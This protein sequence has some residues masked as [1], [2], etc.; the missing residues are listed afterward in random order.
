[1]STIETSDRFS[2]IL[3]RLSDKSVADYYNPF[4]HFSWPESLPD[5][6]YWMTPSL[7]S[8]HGT[9]VGAQLDER[10]LMELSKWESVN[11]YSMNVHGIRELLMEVV[12][13]IHMPGFEVPSEFFHHFI[14]EENE[15]MW[16]FAEF[17]LRYGG[18]IYPTLKLK[19]SAPEDPDVGN[20]LVFS[21]ILLFEEVVDHYN[22]T[23]AEDSRLHETIREVNRIHHKDESRHIAFGR[24]LVSLLFDRVRDR[25]SAEQRTEIEVYLKRYVT[26]TLESFCNPTVYR[27]AGLGDIP[28]LRERV[29]ADPRRHEAEQHAVRKPMSFFV[30]S[31]IF[32]DSSL[33]P[34]DTRA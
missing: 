26:T 13:R 21:R 27:D 31:G 23:M 12:D 33:R 16:F 14:G 19:T 20:L 25:L 24:E 9:E 4:V 34:A 30:R 5:E 6:A 10:Q 17:C 8:T 2:T 1:M 15:H 18:K 22:M 32:S 29:L 11:F 7:V 28:R 3:K